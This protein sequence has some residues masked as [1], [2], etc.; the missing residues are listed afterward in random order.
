M[1]NFFRFSYVVHNW[2]IKVVSPAQPIRYYVSFLHAVFLGPWDWI[3]FIM[4][5]FV[6]MG[7]RHC[8]CLKLILT[9]HLGNQVKDRNWVSYLLIKRCNIDFVSVQILAVR[10]LS[11]NSTLIARYHPLELPPASV[12]TRL[13][14]VTQEIACAALTACH[15]KTSASWQQPPARDTMKSGCSMLDYAYVS[16]VFDMM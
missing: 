13:R 10:V 12:Q 8:L 15:M 9:F 14:V 3:C 5:T 6:V 7:I 2:F 16:Y 11:V 1:Y 4:P